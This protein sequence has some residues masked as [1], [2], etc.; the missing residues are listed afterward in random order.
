MD[1]DLYIEHKGRI[2]RLTYLSVNLTLTA[3]S[4]GGGLLVGAVVAAFE[5]AG[6]ALAIFAWLFWLLCH[7]GCFYAV[8]AKRWHDVGVSGWW[9]LLL[10]VPFIGLVAW[11][12]LL[13]WPGK[14]VEN[15]YGE[16]RS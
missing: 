11:L 5:G 14:P 10:F 12:L 4:V 13:F 16:P 8:T 15:K 6:P 9:N 2:G 1:W 7:A 3:V